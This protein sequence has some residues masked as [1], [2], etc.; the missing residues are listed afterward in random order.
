[1]S[2]R[3]DSPDMVIQAQDIA[4]SARLLYGGFSFLTLVSHENVSHDSAEFR[5]RRGDRA[6]A[7]RV[8]AG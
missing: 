7:A 3:R 8:V 2:R 1:M 4:S 5:F 6:G